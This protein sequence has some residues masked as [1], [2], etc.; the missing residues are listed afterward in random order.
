MI[1]A[2]NIF[3]RVPWISATQAARRNQ[4]FR[5]FAQREDSA[6]RAGFAT[7]IGAIR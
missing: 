2:K 6:R 7:I 1:S 5:D 3:R 4:R